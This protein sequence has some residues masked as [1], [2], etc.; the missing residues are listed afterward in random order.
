LGVERKKQ[1]ANDRVAKNGRS[2]SKSF[3]K[4]AVSAPARCVIYNRWRAAWADAFHK[5]NNRTCVAA[6][7]NADL[8]LVFL[9]KP[10]A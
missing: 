8:D 6:S 3:V 4:H 5:L 1:S 2:V 9:L 7:C 10:I